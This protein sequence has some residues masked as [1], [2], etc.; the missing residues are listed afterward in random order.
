VLVSHSREV[1]HWELSKANDA[2]LRTSALLGTLSVQSVHDQY[3][4]ALE[5][6]HQLALM[7]AE[8]VD[9]L[10]I[11]VAVVASLAC[12]PLTLVLFVLTAG[13]VCNITFVELLMFF[14]GAFGG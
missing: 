12:V 4:F 11:L 6:G 2:D 10:I 9:R 8:L 5:G 3:P 7:A 13:S 1:L 14:F